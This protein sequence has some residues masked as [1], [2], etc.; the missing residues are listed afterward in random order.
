MQRRACRDRCEPASRMPTRDYECSRNDSGEATLSATPERGRADSPERS[1]SPSAS[2]RKCSL[3]LV[4]MHAPVRCAA[5]SEVVAV[6]FDC[7]GQL[8]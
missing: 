3:D 1:E 8:I 5:Q 4:E 7:R 6:K 2:A